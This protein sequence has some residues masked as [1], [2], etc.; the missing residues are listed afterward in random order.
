MFFSI[1]KEL[2]YVVGEDYVSTNEFELWNHSVTAH[3]VNSVEV[4]FLLIN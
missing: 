2:M 1:E 4:W 3:D